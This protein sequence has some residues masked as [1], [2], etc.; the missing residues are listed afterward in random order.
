V[1]A[2]LENAVTRDV[3]TSPGG[4]TSVR[5]KEASVGFMKNEF[6]KGF[7]SLEKIIWGGTRIENIIYQ[8][9]WTKNL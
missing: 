6:G 2:V 5:D 9:D 1:I 3:P 4:T 8:D 7:A